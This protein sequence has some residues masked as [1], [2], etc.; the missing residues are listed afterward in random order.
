MNNENKTK[1]QL[2]AEMIELR[3]RIAELEASEIQYKQVEKALKESEDKYSTI[4]EKGNDGIAIA[5]HGKAKFANSMLLELFGFTLEETLEKQFIDYIT[6]ESREL[7]MERYKKRIAGEQI[8]N[9]YEIELYTKDGRKIPVE[10]NASLIEYEGKPA[11]LAIVRDISDRRK[12]DTSL[13]ESEKKF[14][15]LSDLLPETVYETDIEGTLTFV[16]RIGFKT[17]GYSQEDL[18]KGLN[19]FQL[20]VPEDHEK[21]KENIT[22]LIKGEEIGINE[23]TARRKDGSKY[24][25]AIHSSVIRDN[26]GKSVGLRG[27]IINITEH[28]RADEKIKN[29]AENLE[30]MV[31][32]RTKALRESEGRLQAI[33]TGIGDL[34]TI[35]N[36]DL[37]IIWANQPIRELW[38]EIVGR[39]CY[40]AYKGLTVP[41]PDCT[42]KKV[43]KEG[44]TTVTEQIST[45]PDGTQM[46][47]LVTSSPVRD[48]KGEIIAVVEV[49]KDITERKK[50]ERE[51]KNYTENLE[52]IVEE[53]TK[54]LKEAEAKQ[55]AVLK[56]IGDL[57]T[58]QNKE[59]DIIWANQ[60]IKEHWGSVVGKKCYK[61]YKCFDERC[62]QCTVEMV[63]N[64]G[65]TFVSEQV[66]I[67]PDGK[68][69]NTLVTS[70]P[71]RDADG[72]IV[73]VVEVVKDI[74]ERKKLEV[75]LRES[76][77]RYRGLYKSSIDGIISL[78]VNGNILECNQAYAN[79]LGY[80]KEELYALNVFDLTPDKWIEANKKYHTQ[81][82]TLGYSE[83][84]EKEYI[85]KD[86]SI[87]SIAT[88]GWSINKEGKTIGM[89]GIIRDITERKQAEK[90][91]KEYTENLEQIVEERTSDLKASEERYRGLYESSI[92]GIA[93]L[94]MDGNIIECNQAYANML[95]YTKDV[96]YNL[97]YQDLTPER[98]YDIET[99]IFTKQILPKGYS[100]VYE[101]E[102]IK[103]DGTIF[104][105]SVRGWLIKDK[106]STPTGI[107]K[108]VRDISEQKKMERQLKKYTEDLEASEKR[109]RGLYESSLDGIVF[110]DLE[111]N[112]L[113]CNQAFADMLE[114]TKKQLYN[115]NY[116]ELFPSKLFDY[117]AKTLSDQIF[118]SGYSDELETEAL[119]QDGTIISVSVKAWRIKDQENN[120]IGMWII[121][122]DI[123]Q[124]KKLE[125]QLKNYA[126]N[127][128]KF[129]EKRMERLKESEKR[130]R[131][132]YESS[133]DGIFSADLEKNI[134]ECNQ[135]FAD[136]LGYT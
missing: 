80:S 105:V 128:E 125:S 17:T 63:F 20:V 120:P 9:R 57:I 135:A 25:V 101:K 134:I 23:Y 28:K 58:I 56:G 127:L 71:V 81:I 92:D 99:D 115:A 54:E 49:D 89:W 130:Y 45:I 104:P 66:V 31:E 35:Q 108:I 5:Q 90:K 59:L 96:L 52:N 107:W 124:Q 69:M 133:A 136:M 62:P 60:P 117:V 132:L 36:K 48:A 22:R 61:V 50:L 21:L 109:Y 10:I 18:D 8:P 110:L 34:I 102:H 30:K 118:T 38:G 111:G 39:K 40:E 2:I 6:P 84:F 78:D 24:P 11:D 13:R 122:H 112:I 114:Y 83:E 19:A 116:R 29:Y 86:G 100:N 91:I 93:S 12:V 103:K 77:E 106:E 64:E 55:Q 7:V 73:A 41:C 129:V 121:V 119:K 43:F 53:R 15:E 26:E 4:V 51:L 98:W 14:R 94:D 72:K 82:L 88:R 97:T 113:E 67:N 27:I 79:L 65:K 126:E 85:R 70:S 44:K 46:H 87:V 33:L 37:D 75:E 123:T 3:Q 95:G 1:E 42:V 32:E 47:V 76:E 68:P 131:G 74:T 16:N